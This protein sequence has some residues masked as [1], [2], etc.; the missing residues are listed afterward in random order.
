MEGKTQRR[1]RYRSIFFRGG[2][3]MHWRP[4]FPDVPTHREKT[5]RN[6]WNDKAITGSLSKLDYFLATSRLRPYLP[7]A[8]QE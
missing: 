6:I 4:I 1:A 3:V 8:P 7:L 2:Q 5:G